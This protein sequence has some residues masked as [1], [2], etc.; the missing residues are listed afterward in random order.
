MSD[1][2]AALILEIVARPDDD[3][4]REVLAD[5][6]QA[7]GDPR[8]ELISLQ[9]LASRGNRERDAR[10]QELLEAHGTRWLGALG[11]IADSCRFDRGFPTRL[12]LD[13]EV[14]ADDPRWDAALDDPA[15]ATL[16][17]IHPGG[18]HGRIYRRFLTSPKLVNLRRVQVYDRESLEGFFESTAPIEHV[19]YTWFDTDFDYAERAREE[20]SRARREQRRR[21]SRVERGLDPDLEDDDDDDYYDDT[22]AQDELEAEQATGATE[23]DS[24]LRYSLRLWEHVASRDSV[25]SLGIEEDEL[26]S[27]EW[28]SWFHRIRT[29]AVGS[30]S[31][32]LR[33]HLESW[34]A[35]DQRRITFAPHGGLEPSSRQF[36]WDYKI[37]L[38]PH[39]DGAVAR[40]SGDWMI[41][42]IY[43]LRFLPHEV[44]R[45][46]IEYAS[47]DRLRRIRDEVSRPGLEVVEVPLRANNFTWQIR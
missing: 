1:E 21:A 45:V 31:A 8:G 40:I 18:T 30:S 23:D 5:L 46:E 28:A 13:P 15:L 20:A 3:G 29:L 26:E 9:L 35:E 12:G 41:M 47:D 17:E 19:A 11:R 38:A 32:M 6:L 2:V 44:T 33:R 39:G 43:L 14:P 16:E 10:I 25:T 7:R 37:D 4:P 36:P 27:L 22:D 34:S 42:P 24:K